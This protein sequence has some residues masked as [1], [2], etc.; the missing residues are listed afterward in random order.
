MSRPVIVSES[1]DA[2]YGQLV[3]IG[4]HQ[5]RADEG[6]DVGGKDTGPT[7][8]EY[9]KAGLGACT[10][11]TLRAFADRHHWP[12]EQ[13]T[14]S[15]RHDRVKAPDGSKT[16]Q[17]ERTIHLQGN[18]SEEQRE[19]LLQAADRCPVSKTLEAAGKVVTHLSKEPCADL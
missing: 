10:T 7:P 6:E 4:R 19:R 9:L 17:F 15:V 18:L 2:P 16:D 11:V 14:V 1:D 8:Y 12:L 3:L 5:L 13:V